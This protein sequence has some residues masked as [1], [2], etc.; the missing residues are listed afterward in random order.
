MGRYKIEGE[1]HSYTVA[2]D[3]HD[4]IMSHGGGEY[5]TELIRTIKAVHPDE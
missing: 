3:A 4:W 2:G 5:L 1:R